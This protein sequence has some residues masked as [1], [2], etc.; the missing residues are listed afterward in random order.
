MMTRAQSDLQ[1]TSLQASYVSTKADVEWWRLPD[2]TWLARRYVGQ[3]AELRR[4]S[5]NACNC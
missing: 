2:G 1:L 5:A 3:Y 4:F